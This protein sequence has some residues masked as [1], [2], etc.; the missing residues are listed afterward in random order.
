VGLRVRITTAERSKA[1]V[2]GRSLA[3]VAGSNPAGDVDVCV[4]CCQLDVCATG[5]SYVQRSPA[6]CDAIILC[7]LQTARMRR[8][9]LALGGCARDE[10]NDSACLDMV[11][12]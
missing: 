5:P 11:P 12:R 10:G 3:G 8:T 7:D 2:C 1:R 6:D 4:V 9:W